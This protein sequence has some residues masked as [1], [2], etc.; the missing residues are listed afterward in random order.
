VCCCGSLFSGNGEYA[1]VLL[2]AGNGECVRCCFLFSGKCKY[3]LAC[4]VACAPTRALLLTHTLFVLN[5]ILPSHLQTECIPTGAARKFCYYLQLPICSSKIKTNS[6]TVGIRFSWWCQKTPLRGC[7]VLCAR[8]E[9]LIFK[10]R[11]C[12]INYLTA[13]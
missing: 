7:G 10:R 9:G 12:N 3:M 11:I 1:V 2:F 8:S 5:F 6:V 4:C 13:F